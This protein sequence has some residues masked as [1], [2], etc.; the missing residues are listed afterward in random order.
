M[1]I[2]N[3]KLEEKL[4]ILGIKLSPAK[5]EK[6]LFL[7]EYFDEAMRAEHVL[8]KAGLHVTSGAPPPDIRTGCDLAIGVDVEE[9]GT[10]EKDLEAHKVEVF[11]VAFVA[12]AALAPLQ[13][14]VLIKQVDFGEYMMVRCGNMKVTYEK[15]S[16]TVVNVSGGGC[17]DIPLLVIK[18]VGTRLGEGPRPREIGVTLCAYTLDKAYEKAME[19]FKGGK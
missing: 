8:S 18:I 7:F 4:K 14:S 15:K 10:A 3:L 9:F 11:D 6:A 19:I 13:L 5:P 16:G 2:D 12:E 1:I 17:P